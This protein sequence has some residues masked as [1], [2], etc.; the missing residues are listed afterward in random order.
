ME[1]LFEEDGFSDLVEACSDLLLETRGLLEAGELAD[2]LDVSL[3]ADGEED[4]V[5]DSP[6]F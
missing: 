5:M 2:V 6:D 4:S 1:L 3:V